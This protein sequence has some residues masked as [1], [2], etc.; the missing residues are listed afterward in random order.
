MNREQLFRRARER[1]FLVAAIVLTSVAC[2]RATKEY[3]EK[4]LV[5]AGRKSLLED[6]VRIEYAENKG[7]FLGAGAGL[8]QPLRKL[9]FTVGAGALAF[10]LLGAALF[11]GDVT[12]L[13][14]LAFALVSSGGLGN[15]WDR[16]VRGAVVDF[17]N[18]GIGPV[19]T[20]IFNVADVAIVAGVVLLLLDNRK[21]PQAAPPPT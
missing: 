12:R 10:G 1:I 21:P 16:L 19:R 9:I 7:A 11:K 3:A 4:T 13:Q 14:I 17:M 15:F 18:L 8:P 6:T 5:D 2:D 20:G